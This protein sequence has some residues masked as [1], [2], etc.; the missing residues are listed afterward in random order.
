M[1]TTFSI[2]RGKMAVIYK[3][4]SPPAV[5]VKLWAGVWA[6]SEKCQICA[7]PFAEICNWPYSAIGI[8][9][10]YSTVEIQMKQL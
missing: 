3:L 8:N 7:K 5:W 2:L 4:E 9:K 6:L 10:E 1:D